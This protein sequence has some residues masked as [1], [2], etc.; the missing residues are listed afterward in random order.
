MD[1]KE[2]AAIRELLDT[3]PAEF[4]VMEE[5]VSQEVLDEYYDFGKSLDGLD[6]AAILAQRDEWQDLETAAL[7]RLLVLLA[8][9]GNVKSF[10]QLEAILK[11]RADD[12][13]GF[14]SV[15]MM[16]ARMKLE[17]MLTDSPSGFILSGLGGKGNMLRYYFV[18]TSKEGITDAQARFIEGEIEEVCRQRASEM[19]EIEHESNYVLV[20]IL[21]SVEEVIGDVIEEISVACPFL[22]KE[23]LCTNVSK[24]TH[25][26]IT[27]WMN[28]ELEDEA[29]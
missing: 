6:R 3:L 19:E 1:S 2:L 7:K 28:D 13:G 18:L 26:F 22:E 14:G 10:R 15:T 16:Y 17:S 27:R 21:V 23:F 29:V 20:R 11:A 9:E 5:G 12:L 25:E 8:A 4:Q 24:P